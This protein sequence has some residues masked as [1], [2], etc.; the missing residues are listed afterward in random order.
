MLTKNGNIEVLARVYTDIKE[1]SDLIEE[2]KVLDQNNVDVKVDFSLI[3][4]IEDVEQRN[5]ELRKVLREIRFYCIEKVG[6]TSKWKVVI[7]QINGIKKYLVLDQKYGF[8]NTVVDYA[9][10]LTQGT[11]DNR[12]PWEIE[13]SEEW[14]SYSY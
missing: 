14:E 3:S 1:V 4:S 12:E 13:D 9:S 5:I 2:S 7:E 8:G 11:E 6:Q 10:L